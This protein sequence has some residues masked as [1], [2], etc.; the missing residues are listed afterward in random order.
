MIDP[1]VGGIFSVSQLG[2]FSSFTSSGDQIQFTI[3]TT[4]L[5]PGA[6][7]PGLPPV[8][9][10]G[11]E[12]IISPRNDTGEMGI[13]FGGTG[14]GPGG[15]TIF[16]A[17]GSGFLVQQIGYETQHGIAFS[18]I[19]PIGV[20]YVY[21]DATSAVQ[22]GNSYTLVNDGSQGSFDDFLPCF[23]S[24]TAF[25]TEEGGT[26]VENLRV[27]QRITT[28]SGILREI[29]WIGRREIDCSRHPRP[30]AVWPVRIQQD[31]FGNGLPARDLWLSPDH[32]VCVTCL[33][34]VLIPIK[35]LV[36]GATVAQV[37]RDR[38]TYWHVE[39]DDHDI[40]LAEGLPCESFL[41]TG[42]RSGFENAGAFTLLHPDFAVSTLGDFCRPLILDG[43]IIEGVRARL[44]SR[45][46]ALGWSETADANLHALADG[47]ILRPVFAGHTARFLVPAGT[48]RLTIESRSFVPH[49]HDP[50]SGDGRRLGVPFRRITVNDG[51]LRKEISTEDP[52]LDDGFNFLQSHEHGTW[53]WTTGSSAVP[54]SLWRE[55]QDA[56][57]LCLE[58]APDRGALRAWVPPEPKRQ[59]I[60]KLVSM[61]AG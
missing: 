36:N 56:F 22:V 32:S 61:V 31:A 30:S 17:S 12:F 10:P 23:V 52:L 50:R 19:T 41:D 42:V 44:L 45:A 38:V 25:A 48:E 33:D 14:N 51:F 29:K 43:S 59:S 53:R 58:L 60:I 26:R 15:G 18:L 21:L 13:Q 4:D 8:F 16:F 57:F 7:L 34:E 28:A 24:G 5:Q 20:N 6:P 55:C 39:L 49:N 1:S 47:A 27:G 40:L 2:G 46:L 11:S 9:P 3:N 35:Y 54:A 37:P